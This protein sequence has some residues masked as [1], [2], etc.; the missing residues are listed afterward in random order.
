ME[1]Y[2][3]VALSV[4]VAVVGFWLV[5]WFWFTVVDGLAPYGIVFGD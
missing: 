4:L 1:T 2:E 5:V 3:K